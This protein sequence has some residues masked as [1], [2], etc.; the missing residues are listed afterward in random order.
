MTINTN[1]FTYT[2]EG[3]V[4]RIAKNVQSD[5]R[6]IDIPRGMGTDG[7]CMTVVGGEGA[8]HYTVNRVSSEDLENPN[9]IKF[10]SSNG[11]ARIHNS[12]GITPDS[13]VSI[14]GVPE[15]SV[16]CAQRLG[17]LNEYNQVIG[18]AE[19]QTQQT[20]A[21]NS[22]EAIVGMETPKVT[23]TLGI[24]QQMTGSSEGVHGLVSSVIGR[25]SDG[26]IVAAA[27]S[28]TDRTGLDPE[29]SA[30]I[31]DDMVSDYRSKSADYVKANFKGVDTEALGQFFDGLDSNK[32]ADIMR[33][34]FHGKRQECLG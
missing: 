18:N 4:S 26:D 22:P 14:P 8:T 29:Q 17:Y 15:M 34:C 16:A 12:S 28:F 30:L 23:Q 31:I 21:N 5:A 10:Y 25:L 7:S 13:M 3:G 11:A 33:S 24:L 6:D 9:Q 2:N 19:Q 20:P 32:K 1:D 27:K